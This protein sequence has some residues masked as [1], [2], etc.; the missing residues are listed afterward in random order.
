[1]VPQTLVLSTNGPLLFL[2]SERFK[3]S[4]LFTVEQEQNAQEVLKYLIL[5]VSGVIECDRMGATALADLSN[6]LA[7]KD[8]K[9]FVAQS[10]GKQKI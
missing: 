8:M 7:Q 6:E 5:D 10:R 4:I 9:L 2:N 3:D 1:M